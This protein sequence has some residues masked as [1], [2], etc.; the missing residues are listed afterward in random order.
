VIQRSGTGVPVAGMAVAVRSIHSPV[1]SAKTADIINMHRL[2]LLAYTEP[3][4]L[5]PL[6]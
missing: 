3:V 5:C 2:A 1:S 4:K 6:P